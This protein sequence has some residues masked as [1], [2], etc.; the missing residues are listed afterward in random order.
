MKLRD[1]LKLIDGCQDIGLYQFKNGCPGG[2]K[3]IEVPASP[4]NIATYIDCEVDQ[5]QVVMCDYLENKAKP[6]GYIRLNVFLKE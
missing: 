1:V 5:T 3:T 6:L 2:V 4:R